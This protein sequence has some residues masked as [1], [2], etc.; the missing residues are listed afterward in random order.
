MTIVLVL[1]NKTEASL[2]TMIRKWGYDPDFLKHTLFNQRKDKIFPFD[3]KKKR[4]TA[5]IHLHDGKVRLFCKGAAEWVLKDCTKFLDRLG[6]EYKL[7]DSKRLELEAVINNMA[8]QALRTLV[9]AHLDF[10]S[11][12]ALPD[13]WETNPPD[14]ADLC[15][16]CIVGI[17]DPIRGDVREAVATAQRAGVV[18]RMVTGDNLATARAIAKQCGILTEESGEVCIEGPGFRTMTPQGLDSMLSKLR[19]LAR[20]SPDDKRLL[21][22]RLNGHTIPETEE[23]WNEMHKGQV[24][25]SW[26]NDK[27]RLLPGTFCEDMYLL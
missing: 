18:V 25:V 5:I 19:V 21:V 22:S 23:D 6:S 9:L 24:G 15:V 11:A 20:S 8:N 4:S 17:I 27:D 13:D 3:S 12:A 16:D 7:T 10:A 14:S 1:G 2:M 26:A